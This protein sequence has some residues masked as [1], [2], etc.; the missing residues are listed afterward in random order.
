[1]KIIIE[2]PDPGAEDEIILR[3]AALDEELMALIYALKAG[4]SRLTAYTEDGIVQLSPKDIFYF[5]SVDNRVF[6][7]CERSVYEV[8]Q[9]LYTLEEAYPNSDF[10]RISKSVI[11][12]VSKIVKLSPTLNGRFEAHLKNGEKTTISRQYVPNLKQKL[13]L[14]EGYRR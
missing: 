5:E 4:R 11:V 3:C 2:T 1:M 14:T 12:N 10:L 6:A 7:Y 8:R 9:K 13:G